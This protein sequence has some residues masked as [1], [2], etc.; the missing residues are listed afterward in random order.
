MIA[1]RCGYA[2][3]HRRRRRC[4]RRSPCRRKRATEA[5]MSHAGSRH[6][7]LALAA[8]LLSLAPHA[9]AAAERFTL[10]YGQIPSTVRGVSS[11]YTFIATHKGFLARE[12]VTLEY[13]PIPG[14]TDKMIA[15]LE[16][17]R[18]DVTQ[19]ATPT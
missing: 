12:E 13:V 14:G 15:A 16:Q 18:V 2:S 3:I 10:R 5:M 8:V 4:G 9:T 17:G 19:T 1:W 6:A 11:L 7:V